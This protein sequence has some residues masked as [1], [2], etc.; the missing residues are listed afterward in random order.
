MKKIK[1]YIFLSI[2]LFNCTEQEST[3]V[4]QNAES[5]DYRVAS[6]DPLYDIVL[7]PENHT[8]EALDAYYQHVKET[9]SD[10]LKY[11]N[12]R[13]TIIDHIYLQNGHQMVGV[14]QKKIEYYVN[15]I[16]SMEYITNM[17]ILAHMLTRLSGY[18]DDEKI[19]QI[20]ILASDRN[21]KFIM[22]HFDNPQLIFD[23]PHQQRGIRL[24]KMLAYFKSSK[25]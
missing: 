14:P 13:K 12:L 9:R 2:L 10:E 19:R 22:T 1:L 3:L 16:I 25:E 5:S 18:W 8:F 24:L 20:S 17:E 7:N 4:Q 15:E 21:E 6:D 11:D 23:I